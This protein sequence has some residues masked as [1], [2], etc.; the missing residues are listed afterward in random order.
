MAIRTIAPAGGEWST[1]TTW[2]EGAVPT[3]AD[4]VVANASSGPLAITV[5]GAVCRSMDLT[6]FTS[7]WS[8]STTFT[9]GGATGGPGDAILTIPATGGNLTFGGFLHLKTSA[10]T[11]QILRMMRGA[12]SHT[13]ISGTGTV[14][15]GADFLSTS[16]RVLQVTSGTF[17]SNGYGVNVYSLMSLGTT[18]RTIILSATPTVSLGTASGGG[19]SVGG[20]NYTVLA[21][22]TNFVMAS[23][24]YFTGGAATYG[25]VSW[26]AMATG[27]IGIDSTIASLS[28]VGSGTMAAF[29]VAP[30]GVLTVA[31]NVTMTGLSATSRLNVGSS[32]FI[33]TE[34]ESGKSATVN[35]GGTA[36]LSNVNFMDVNFVGPNTPVSGTLLGDGLGNSG[37]TFAAPRTL[38]WV[39]NAGNWT[40]GSHWALSSGGTPGASY[41]L[42]QDS[43]VFDQNSFTLPTQSVTGDT[44][45][46]GTDVSVNT[47]QTGCRITSSLPTLSFFGNFTIM[48]TGQFS[49]AETLYCRARSVVTLSS[50]APLA[51][52]AFVLL[53]PG[54]TLRLTSDMSFNT[55]GI[56]K[57]TFDGAGFAVTLQAFIADPPSSM[58][59]TTA[60]RELRMGGGVWTLHNANSTGWNNGDVNV[61]AFTLVPEGSVLW[62]TGTPSPSSIAISAAKVDMPPTVIALAAGSLSAGNGGFREITHLSGVVTISGASCTSYISSGDQVR[63]IMLTSNFTVRGNLLLSGTNLTITGAN[64]VICSPV[65]GDVTVR[66]GST[67]FPTLRLNPPINSQISVFDPVI[68]GSL[69]LVGPS[70]GHGFVTLNEPVT[71]TTFS[72]VGNLAATRRI[73]V[74][75]PQ[76]GGR[77][78]ITAASTTCTNVDFT[79][80]DQAGTAAWTGTSKTDTFTGYTNHAVE[81]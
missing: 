60:I 55:L 29:N 7:T 14:K 73:K 2:V 72:A 76:W 28:V 77:T 35:L 18:P 34:F 65:A 51:S 54:G 45:W 21:A 67:S 1:A 70:T 32:A 13:Y 58:I 4:D 38:Y 15:L 66:T 49:I 64:S 79:N 63:S 53:A 78:T 9:I 74:Y 71:V 57:G 50:P 30:N 27:G 61:S 75:G 62:I 37:I 33:S 3:D 48:G 6:G 24:S 17:D 26:A 59:E 23:G 44:P 5:A 12:P 25:N 43:V 46:L 69:F 56:Y 68:A 19:L 47:N 40:A 39:G 22:T 36:T 8:G 11:P 52:T 16:N 42:A 20:S 41:P 10:S 80:I 31:G 81:A